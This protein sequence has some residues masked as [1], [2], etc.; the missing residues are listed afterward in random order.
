MFNKI[1]ILPLFILWTLTNINC[2]NRGNSSE[3]EES[4]KE[5]E[6]VQSQNN[7]VWLTPQQQKAIGLKLGKVTY[8]NLEVSVK[9][10]GQLE[11]PPQYKAEVSPYIGGNVKRIYFS[12]GDY[13]KKGEPLALLEH[14][15]YIEIQQKFRQTA[16]TLTYLKE[17]F[18]RKKELYTQEVSSARDYQKALADY[19]E[20]K[21][22]YQGLQSKIQLLGL[23]PEAV[24][25]GK[26]FSSIALKSPINGNINTVNINIGAYAA[27]GAPLFTLSDNHHIHADF[28]VYEKDIYKVRKGQLINF[29][30]SNIPGEILQAKIF[31]IG[32]NFENDPRALHVHAKIITPEVNLLTG[33]YINGRLLVNNLKVKSLPQPAIV[34]EG[35]KDYIFVKKEEIET[36]PSFGDSTTAFKK[37]EIITGVSDQGF[38]EI[39][40]L[41]PLPDSA[42]VVTEGAYYLLADLTKEENEHSH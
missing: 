41:N 2:S 20:A 26:I 7:L 11:I 42:L 12:E 27:P 1:I 3:K 18:L 21:A 29:T 10:T 35:G 28:M 4:H 38:T 25:E 30:V 23:N 13:V 16:S 19:N 39:R 31:S 34:R 22:K 24:R 36:I 33:M 15:D 6:A 40:L 5:T 17:E 14:P 8:H 9:V 32:K 37:V